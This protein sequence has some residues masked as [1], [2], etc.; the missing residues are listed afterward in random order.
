MVQ[1][2]F[3]C[4]QCKGVLS[5]W[6]CR[7]RSRNPV[8]ADGIVDNWLWQKSHGIGVPFW[9]PPASPMC[10]YFVYSSEVKLVVGW[11]IKQRRYEKIYPE[12]LITRARGKIIMIDMLITPWL[13]FPRTSTSLMNR[14][15]GD[16]TKFDGYIWLFSI[17]NSRL[18]DSVSVRKCTWQKSWVHIAQ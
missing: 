17:S 12:Q 5:V 1:R 8:H 18:L 11:K 9:R 6:G 2:Y 13:T 7:I 3:H 16:G 10:L 14:W 4:R 15:H